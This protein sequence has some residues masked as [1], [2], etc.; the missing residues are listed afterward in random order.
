MTPSTKPPDRR[1]EGADDAP[2]HSRRAA[3]LSL[4]ARRA[5]ERALAT[6]VGRICAQVLEGALE[7]DVLRA[8]SAM[9]FDLFLAAIPLLALAGWVFGQL[10]RDGSAVTATSLLIGSTP[11]AVR[12]LAE[13]HLARFDPGTVAPVALLGSLWLSSSAAVTCMALLDSRGG[14]TP[15]TWWQRRALAIGWVLLATIVFGL[16]GALALM[17]SGGPLRF[18]Q[19][20]VS[21]EVAMSAGHKLSLALIYLLAIALLAAFFRVATVRPGLRRSVW[22]G[23][24]LGAG[25]VMLTSTGFSFYAT[26]IA[27]YALYYGSLAAVAVTLVWLWLVCVFVL[28]GAELNRVLEHVLRDLRRPVASAVRG[29]SIQTPHPSGSS[30]EP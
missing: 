24:F 27:S 5:G 4:R 18:L 20:L 14:S 8:A 30:A 6:R 23:A 16:G 17:L 28:L 13:G 1:R 7:G 15:R 12:A 21:E 26:R 2:A 11:D 3:T 10:A 29:Q 19:A 22:P 9:A 25:L